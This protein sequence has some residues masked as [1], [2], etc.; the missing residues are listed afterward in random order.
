MNLI[1]KVILD[2]KYLHSLSRICALAIKGVIMLKPV[3]K[4]CSNVEFP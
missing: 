4:V 1:K 2:Q 3:E